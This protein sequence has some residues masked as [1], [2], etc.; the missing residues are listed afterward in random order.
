MR[1]F[2]SAAGTLCARSSQSMLGQSS[3]SIQ[4]ARSGRQCLRNRRTQAVLS[5]G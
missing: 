1:A 3:D 4:S 2:N 5:I